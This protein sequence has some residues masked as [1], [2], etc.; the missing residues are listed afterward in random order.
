MSGSPRERASRGRWLLVASPQD[1]VAAAFQ[2]L[3]AAWPSAAWVADRFEAL[4]MVASATAREPVV[5]ALF[6]DAAIAGDP[7]SLEVSFR[8]VDPSV[9]VVAWLAADAPRTLASLPVIRSR[10]ESAAIREEL[11]K[12][13]VPAVEDAPVP[14]ESPAPAEGRPRTVPAAIE[15]RPAPTRPDPPEP[16]TPIVETVASPTLRRESPLGDVDLVRAVL[17]GGGALAE[18][19]VLAIRQRIGDREVELLPPEPLPADGRGSIVEVRGERAR[20]GWLRSGRSPASLL[21]PWASWLAAWL[22]LDARQRDLERQAL[23]DDLTGVGNRRA[24]EA[25]LAETLAAARP[26]RRPVTLM[27]FDIDNFK[28]YNDR[29]GHEAGDEVLREVVQV[30]RSVI[31]KGDHVFRIGGDEFVVIFSDPS[32][33]R[34]AGAAPLESIEQVVR[35]FQ[36]QVFR[37]R[38]PK[39][40]LEAPGTVTISA[41]LAT[42]PWD[43][44]DASTLLRH[45]DHLALQ[46]KRSGKNQLTFG[47]GAQQHADPG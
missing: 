20:L 30:L 45:A 21:A 1:P 29:F 32:G 18:A 42:Y 25:V 43:G 39:L 7:V 4:A 34:S 47:P 15:I 28:T 23:A 2:D 40:G 31:R 44:L 16:P 19:A 41:G 6:S 36:S 33:P 24:F 38:L 46:S 14:P 11:L 5:G 22:D 17:A 37:M 35:R 8:E 9:E 26:L 13:A 3:A 10:A 27:V 12:G